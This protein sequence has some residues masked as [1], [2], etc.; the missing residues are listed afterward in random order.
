MEMG[1]DRLTVGPQDG[2]GKLRC[3]REGGLERGNGY[4]EGVIW[5]RG[6]ATGF[7]GVQKES[8]N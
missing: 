1:F 8:S 5:F 7:V 4:S 6:A 3:D 2:K